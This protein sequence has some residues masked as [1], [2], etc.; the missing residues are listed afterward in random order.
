MRRAA[1]LLVLLAGCA[2]EVDDEGAQMQPAIIGGKPTPLSELPATVKIDRCTAVKIAPRFLLTAG[3]CLV[4]LSTFAARFG[5]GAPV[6]LHVGRREV[7]RIHVHPRYEEV[8]RS[9]FC[10]IPEVAQKADAPDVGLVELAEPLDGVPDAVM[11]GDVPGI[12]AAVR[13]AGFGCTEGVHVAERRAEISLTTA[14]ATIVEP[15]IARHEGSGLTPDDESVYAGNYVLSGGPVASGG[16]L[17]PGDSGGPVYDAGGRV[18]GV[19]A[20]YTLRDAAVDAVGLPVTN[21]HT[22]IDGASRHG[23]RA[24]VDAVAAGAR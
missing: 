11:A 2:V 21:W 20:N 18:V 1:A 22:R 17:C 4:D 8:C 6:T 24:W 13:L 7:A 19:H 15:A 9:T 3:H 14:P 5:P 12:G 23:V 16:G 10:S